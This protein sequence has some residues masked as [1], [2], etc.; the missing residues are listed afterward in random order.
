MSQSSP[1]S[2]DSE[3]QQTN[4]DVVFQQAVEFISL[5]EQLKQELSD[6]QNRQKALKA[7]CEDVK[8]CLDSMKRTVCELRA[9]AATNDSVS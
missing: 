1:L 2:S 8:L 6:E 7:A 5:S 9:R 4:V 3:P